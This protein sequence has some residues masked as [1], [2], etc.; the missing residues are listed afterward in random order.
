MGNGVMYKCD[1][2]NQRL[3]EG[4]PPGCVE[5]CPRE[6]MLIGSRKEIYAVAEERIKA[7]DGYIYGKE[8][9]GGTATLY[10]SPVPFELINGTMKKNRASPT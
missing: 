8:E 7:M 2:C 10:V 6:A 5:A 4:K 3:K 9:N 1:L